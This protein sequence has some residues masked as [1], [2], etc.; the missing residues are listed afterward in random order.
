MWEEESEKYDADISRVKVWD[1][2]SNLFLDTS[3]TQEDLERFAETI[4]ESPFSFEELGHIL[5]FEVSPVCSPN[6]FAWPGG[7]WAGFSSDWLI[8]KCLRQ[9]RKH[10]FKS[11]GRSEKVRFFVHVLGCGPVS[12][13]YFLL[14]R[15]QRKRL[16][17]SS[18]Y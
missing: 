17:P 9:Q 3:W 14:F 7:E 4:A 5:F 18:K 6:L 2:F 13:A 12:E 11:N 15:A 10:R 16:N 1:A 8:P